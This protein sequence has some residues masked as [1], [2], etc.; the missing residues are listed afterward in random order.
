M[1]PTIRHYDW[2]G[3]CKQIVAALLAYESPIW[4]SNAVR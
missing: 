2:S 1:N 4:W 3:H